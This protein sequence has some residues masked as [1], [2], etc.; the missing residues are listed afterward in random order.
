MLASIQKR[1][2]V[3]NIS[4]C[5]FLLHET[6]LRFKIGTYWEK[7]FNR[8]KKHY[9][10]K[11]L[12]TDPV[13]ERFSNHFLERFN[14]IKNKKWKHYNLK[15]CRSYKGGYKIQDLEKTRRSI[16]PEEVRESKKKPTKLQ[17]RRK[18][19]KDRPNFWCDD[20]KMWR[21]EINW[22]M[23]YTKTLTARGTY[24]KKMVKDILGEAMTEGY[25][26]FNKKGDNWW[27]KNDLK[28]NHEIIHTSSDDADHDVN[29]EEGKVEEEKDEDEDEEDRK[30]I[31]SGGEEEDE[32]LDEPI[33]ETEQNQNDIETKFNLD[34]LGLGKLSDHF[35]EANDEETSPSSEGDKSEEKEFVK[36]YEFGRRKKK[37]RI[38]TLSD[39][40]V[41]QAFLK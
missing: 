4:R 39:M 11:I 6:M 12:E 21:I 35:S 25:S 2:D 40:E 18:Q 3:A 9:H 37:Q 8:V 41:S 31:I 23:T 17:I 30:E 19:W 20:E 24:S 22:W 15:L 34:K 16:P 33:S 10:R 28:L 27:K 36:D 13:I 5:N 1:S 32:D 14:E 7:H 26:K 29:V 38:A